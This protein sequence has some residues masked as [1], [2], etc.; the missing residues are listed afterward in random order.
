M[1]EKEINYDM[2]KMQIC[3]IITYIIEIAALYEIDLAYEFN[4]KIGIDVEKMNK[5]YS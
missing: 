5:I 4:D 2:I 1:I 3:N